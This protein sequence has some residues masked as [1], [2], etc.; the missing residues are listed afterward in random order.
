M[1]NIMLVDLDSKIPNL[2]LMKLST[3][4]KKKGHAVSFAKFKKDTCLDLFT[5]QADEVFASLIFSYH[6]DRA[7]YLQS[8]FPDAVIGGP[9][10]DPKIRLDPEI[11]RESPDYSLYPDY[12]DSV[13]YVTRG[14]IRRCHFCVVPLM[15]PDGIRFIQWPRHFY[16]GGICRI[17]DDNILAE[18]AIF[19]YVAAWATDL[20][21]TVLFDTL[22]IR[23]VDPEIAVALRGM[24][25]NNRTLNFSFDYTRIEAIVR[26]G[27]RTLMD[28]G[29]HPRKLKFYIYCEN[30]DQIP[31]AKYRF[32]VIREMNCEPFLMVNPDYLTPRLRKIRRRGVSPAI[33]RGLTD[34]EVFE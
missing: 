6:L 8:F 1:S 32:S 2:A 22:D 34:D 13:G 11:E 21:I 4:Y 12:K 31:D 7:A 18:K 20:K 19:M 15:E 5:Q 28:A 17:L 27:V 14:C 10:F 29:F 16:R 3:Y 9:A 24:R 23:F 33:Y 26:K 30:E 25:H